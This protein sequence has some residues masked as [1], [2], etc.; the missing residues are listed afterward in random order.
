LFALEQE[1][2]VTIGQKEH[3]LHTSLGFQF[4]NFPIYGCTNVLSNTGVYKSSEKV[5]FL[6]LQSQKISYINKE[7]TLES[8]LFQPCF[9]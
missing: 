3:T 6:W 5:C 4:R 8:K 7:N 9:V 2:A 1:L